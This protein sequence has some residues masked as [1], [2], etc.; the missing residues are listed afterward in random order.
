MSAMPLI[1]GDDTVP[2]AEIYNS[3]QIAVDEWNARGGIQGVKIE[4][5][6][7]DD[8]MDPAQGVLNVAHKFTADKLMMA[9][10]VPP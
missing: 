4:Q 1:T 2:C 8:A 3:A 5:V 6:M 9:L 10:S 7:G